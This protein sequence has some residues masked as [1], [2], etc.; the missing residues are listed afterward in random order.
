MKKKQKMKMKLLLL[1]LAGVVFVRS[2][3][4]TLCVVTAKRPR[5]YLPDLIHGLEQEKAE[6]LIVDVD[7]STLPSIGALRLQGKGRE[8]VDGPVP[9]PMQQQGIDIARGLLLC[10][11]SHNSKWIALV[12][13]DMAIC[14]GAM[15]TMNTV[16]KRILPFKTA[17]F[18]KFSRAT[19]FPIENIKPYTDYVFDHV[20]E[21][22]HDILLNFN[23]VDG[24]DYIHEGSLFTHVGQMSTIAERNDPVYIA[25]YSSLRD[26]KCG[27]PLFK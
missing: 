9:C 17:R 27:T 4:L 16:I 2:Q 3:D 11:S 7:N 15:A 13:D 24:Y 18:A 21:T 6:Y 23:W 22:P 5:N 20:H 8:C 14:P 10:A 19:V 12:E 1:M 26:E 25:T